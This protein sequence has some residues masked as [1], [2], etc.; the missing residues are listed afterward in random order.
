MKYKTNT[1]TF[2][3]GFLLGFVVVSMYFS[4]RCVWLYEKYYSN[5][6]T[7]QLLNKNIEGGEK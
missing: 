2:L 6:T 3:M 1:F 5:K 7:V 4:S